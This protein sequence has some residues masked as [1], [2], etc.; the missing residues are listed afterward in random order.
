MD[1]R[2][3]INFAAPS[4]LGKTTMAKC[5]SEQYSIPFISGSYRDLVPSTKDIPHSDMIN[6]DSAQIFSQDVQLLNIRQK[7][8][9]REQLFVSDRS[10]LDSAAYMIQKLS[11]RLPECEVEDFIEKCKVLNL[12]FTDKLVMVEYHKAY[13][14]RWKMEDN[15]KRV[16]NR[17]YQEEVSGI[18]MNTL[19]VHMGNIKYKT[20]IMGE[21]SNLIYTL[22]GYYQEREFITEV[23]I[24]R[25]ITHG[26]R[27]RVL[28]KFIN[29]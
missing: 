4:G 2:L 21:F 16:L 12:M 26:N 29:L 25:E 24:L 23:L 18:M 28:D 17:F 14:D 15:G 11:H 6:L 13:W 5:I 3:R 9:S 19:F 27:M 22:S 7:V 10:F 8:F 20:F 1:K